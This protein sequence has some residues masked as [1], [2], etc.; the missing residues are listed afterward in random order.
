MGRLHAAKVAA[1][2][3]EQGDAALVAVAWW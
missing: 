3:R 2:A 1:R